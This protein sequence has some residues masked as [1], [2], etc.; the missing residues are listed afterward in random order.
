[1]ST[2]IGIVHVVALTIEASVPLQFEVCVE[3]TKF[4]YLSVIVYAVIGDP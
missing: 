4:D 3:Y 2:L 1:M